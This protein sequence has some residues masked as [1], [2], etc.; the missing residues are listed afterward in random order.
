M[1][2]VSGKSLSYGV[3]FLAAAGCY[4][5]DGLLAAQ[6]AIS[7]GA[8]TVNNALRFTTVLAIRNQSN[9]RGENLLAIIVTVSFICR[10]VDR[11]IF[12][13]DRTI[14]LTLCFP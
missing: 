1:G 4:R 10:C 3:T 13:H 9:S 2:G 8:K 6:G 7:S 11:I 12:G 5:R 14:T